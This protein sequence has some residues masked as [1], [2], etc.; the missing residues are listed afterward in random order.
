M[1]P[2]YARVAIGL[3]LISAAG[4]VAQ[5]DV[6]LPSIFSNH[7][8][9]QRQQ[10]I[11]VW[12]WAEAGEEVTVVLGEERRTVIAH[13]DGR[14]RVTLDP[15]PAGGPYQLVA[16]GKNSITCDDVLVGDVWICS[17][18]SN[19]EWPLKDSLN[20]AL[21]VLTA[22][23]PRIRL[24]TVPHV[25]S[26]EPRDD[27]EGQWQP[28]TPETAEEFSAVGY[29]FGR[30]VHLAA[31][32]P[33]GL[34]DVSWGGST[35]EAWVSRHRLEQE[36][37]YEQLLAYWD[38]KAETYDHSAALAI[39]E[40]RLKQW[41][42]S[43]LQEGT[44]RARSSEPPFAKPSNP[45][46]G[47]HRPANLY[48][49]MLR[50]I[51]GYAMRGVIWYQGESNAERAYQYRHLFPMMIQDWRDEWG[52]GQFPFYWVQLANYKERSAEPAESAWAELREAQSMTRRRLPNTGEAVTIDVGEADDIH[53]R[54]KQEVGRRLARW[55]LAREYG[56]DVSYDGPRYTSME[57][58]GNKIRLRFAI[59]RNSADRLERG[60]V[61]GFQVAGA[62]RKFVW[63][64]AR[65]IPS[66]RDGRVEVWS[67]EVEDPVAVRY[68]W[69]DNPACNLRNAAK[70]PAPPFRTDDWPGITV[71]TLAPPPDEEVKFTF[72]P[73]G[74]WKWEDDFLG[75][76]IASTLRLNWSDNLLTGT[77]QATL[78]DPELD[79]PTTLAGG[80]VDG[81]KLTFAVRRILNSSELTVVYTGR[82]QGDMVEGTAEV[83]Y[84]GD[85]TPFDWS[86][87]R[88]VEQTDLLG[89]W[90]LKYEGRS[91]VAES[92]FTLKETDGALQGTYESSFAG[93][94]PISEIKLRENELT[95]AVAI[96][97]DGRK[98]TTR[99]KAEPRGDKISGV[100]V[101]EFGSRTFERRFVGSRVAE[102]DDEG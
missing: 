64:Q 24:I 19:M 76:K 61:T 18:Q 35:C 25:G 93:E 43:A 44:Y 50:P 7:M 32:V 59:G 70:L 67:V 68:A 96:E 60:T 31:N 28:C 16:E 75:N 38:R 84:A 56:F 23:H 100:M 72:D 57:K 62:D 95:F 82:L 58:D 29:F 97:F 13:D 3:C 51:L 99:I 55:A 37:Q 6:R 21:E 2:T 4:S 53:P 69:G 48:N 5:G 34:I 81:D 89:R 88:V 30:N 42:E 78:G 9:L 17:G 40:A 33:V 83:R 65:V 22:R 92:T 14:W 91:G 77:H 80:E 101:T 8:V 86:A 90:K 10:Q 54:N 49:G 98:F 66:N 45:L 36:S 87:R 15:R 20:G 1:L 85:V 94:T 11:P 63:A 47:Q 73:S 26:Q 12:G 41:E 46:E 74:T 52:R 102:G 39:Y 79:K 27:F 71:N